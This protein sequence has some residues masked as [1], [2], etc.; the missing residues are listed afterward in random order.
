MTEAAATY[1][2]EYVRMLAYSMPLCGVMMVGGMCLH[3]A[4]ETVWPS[5]IAVLVNVVNVV[6]SWILS[7]AD[8]TVGDWVL[9]NPFAFDLHVAGIA[10]G[11]SISYVAGG[12][13][14]LA[15]LVR[16]VKDLDLR[17]AALRPERTMM[18]R[19][20]R[21]GIPSFCEGISMW[22]VN[23][24]VLQF[25]G[26]IGARAGD[27]AAGEGLQG[28]HII[29][30][31]WEAFSF[32]P[33]FAIGTAAGA[34]AGQYLGAGSASMAMR[35]VI[36]CT[37][38]GVGVMGSLGIVFML[39]GET[40]TSIVSDEP[41]HLEYTPRLLAICGAMQVFFAI[42][43]VFRQGLRGVGDTKWTF[44]LTTVSSYGVRLP[45]AYLLG[46]HFGLGLP[47]IWY[48]LC[49]EFAVRSALFA[50]RF[51]QGGWKRIEV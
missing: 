19:I 16:G 9:M 2:I 46:V 45:A 32:M 51:F 12:L 6:A 15:I 5:L 10:A 27:G 17:R 11:S 48:G 36:R 22:A 42:T 18:W 33:G 24:F 13:A 35:A 38:L 34:L 4:G 30:I 25:I 44:I 50:G 7:G 8:I 40:L 20:V 29:A 3:G 1:L 49:G 31:Q 28:A 14:T 43:M 23:L 21:I 39:F 37:I 26:I 41:V 47:G